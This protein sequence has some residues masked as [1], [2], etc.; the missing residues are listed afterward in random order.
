MQVDVRTK[1]R[2]SKTGPEVVF[3]IT[4]LPRGSGN[5]AAVKRLGETAKKSAMG[6]HIKRMVCGSTRLTLY[7]RS[8]LAL[9]KT[10]MEWTDEQVKIQD[11]PGQMSLFRSIALQ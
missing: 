2:V 11:V 5:R 4:L 1:M 3:S 7:L 9:M 10:I 6:P 8:S